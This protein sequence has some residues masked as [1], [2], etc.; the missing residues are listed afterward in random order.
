MAM[1]KAI[2]FDL[3]NTL[4]DFM[5]VKRQSI[6]EAMTA[7]IGA[8]LKVDK[9][10]ALKVLY[11]IY[12]KHGIEFKTIFQEFLKKTVGKVDYRILA[13][14]IV[15]YR[16]IKLGFLDTYPATH[17]V[18]LELKKRGY[19]L[20]IL[21]DAPKLRAY[22]RL[23]SLKLTDFFDIVVTFDDTKRHKPHKKPFL[24]VLNKLNIEASECLMVGDWPERDIKGAKR[25][26]MRTCFA[27]Y[28]YHQ[29]KVPKFKADYVINDISELLEI[30]K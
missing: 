6:D 5:R 13:S 9:D 16:R 10:K 8:G 20:S 27:K 3:D 25:V 1:I 4:V 2:I 22:M 23:A 29:K 11:S 7:M 19:I 24:K 17:R 14:G 21:S 15:A 30:L 28:G 12:D 26:G 18:L